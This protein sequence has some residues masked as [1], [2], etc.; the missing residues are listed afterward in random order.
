M[1]SHDLLISYCILLTIAP[2]LRVLVLVKIRITIKKAIYQI[3]L[4]FCQR[5]QI[6]CY[7]V[8]FVISRAKF[9]D[10]V[11]IKY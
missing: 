10:D 3:R 11:I 1:L 9:N 5:Y 8:L 7:R 4:F 2:Y 6:F